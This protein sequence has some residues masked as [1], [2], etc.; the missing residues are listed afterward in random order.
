MLV[1]GQWPTPFK[2]HKADEKDALLLWKDAYQNIS[3]L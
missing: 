1:V 3:S 2:H